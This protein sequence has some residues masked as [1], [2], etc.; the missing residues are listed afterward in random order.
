MRERF[1]NAF[2]VFGIIVVAVVLVMLAVDD[3]TQLSA[4]AASSKQGSAHY[5]EINEVYID[6]E[7]G[8][9]YVSTVHGLSARLGQDSKPVGCG[10]TKLGNHLLDSFL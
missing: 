3:H 2:M 7:T 1:L 9:Q 8:C 10:N 5:R 4:D 6:R